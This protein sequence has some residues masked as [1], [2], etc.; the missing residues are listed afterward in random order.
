MK[1]LKIFVSVCVLEMG[2]C[3]TSLK[4]NKQH[5]GIIIFEILKKLSSSSIIIFFYEI[6]KLFWAEVFQITYLQNV[7]K[8]LVVLEEH[9][10]IMKSLR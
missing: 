2:S 9:L 4:N 7:L 8:L 6:L 3:R 5:F 1:N 10:S